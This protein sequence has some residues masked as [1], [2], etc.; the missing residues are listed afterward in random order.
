MLLSKKGTNIA[1]LGFYMI[2]LFADLL[3]KFKT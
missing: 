1:A 2:H 3:I